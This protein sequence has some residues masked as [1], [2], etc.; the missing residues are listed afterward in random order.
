[1]ALATFGTL[2]SCSSIGAHA[3]TTNVVLVGDSLAV[4]AR[5]YLAPLLG[6][7]T[8]TDKSFGGTAPCD[9]LDKDL[10]ISA[11]SVV[12]ISFTGNAIS[13]CMADGAGGFLQGA[14]VVAKYRADVVALIALAQAAHAR[15]LLVGQP[16]RAVMDPANDLVAA[17]NA[18]YVELARTSHVAF[19]DAGATVENPD[20]TLAVSLPCLPG[21][22]E[23]GPDGTNVVRSDDGLHFCPGPPTPTVDCPVYSSGAFRFANAIAT[24]ADRL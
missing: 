22:Q 20:G 23:C 15:T 18:T 21:E 6:S 14:A 5:P 11:G 19:V 4:Q 13:P 7:L 1:M 12:V 2:V 9:A 24:S 17:I 16:V 8:L 3:T 10:Q